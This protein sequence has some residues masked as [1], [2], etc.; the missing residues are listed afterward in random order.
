MEPPCPTYWIRRTS[1]TW[2]TY[3][4]LLSSEVA[5]LETICLS[6]PG[7]LWDGVLEGGAKLRRDVCP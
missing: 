2:P 7:I 6:G 3:Y 5:S 1:S 4:A